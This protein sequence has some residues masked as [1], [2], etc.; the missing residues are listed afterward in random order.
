M[1]FMEKIRTRDQVL[2]KEEHKKLVFPNS[3]LALYGDQD[4]FSNLKKQRS[5]MELMGPEADL[6]LELGFKSK[7]ISGAGH[8]WRERGVMGQMKEHLLE[9]L[10]A[11]QK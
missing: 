11:I 8:F 7:E 5:W 4:G 10:R 6:P 3:T 2:A 9:W 1:S